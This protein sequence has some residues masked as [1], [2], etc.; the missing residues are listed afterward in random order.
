MKGISPVIASIILI[1]IVLSLSSSYLLFTNRLTS[2]QTE[3]G[4][5]G[6]QELTKR[7]SS[8]FKI[9]GV[10]DQGVIIRNIGAQNI[11]NGSLVVIADDIILNYTMPDDIV[12]DSVGRV[13]I[14]GLW[15]IGPGEHTI[16]VRGT[17]FSDSIPVT[18][19]PVKEGRVLDLRFDEGAG[20]VASD[21]SGNKN[22][23]TLKPNATAGPV[24]AQGKFG[25][26]LRFDGIDDGVSVPDAPTLSFG[27]GAFSVEFWMRSD[28]AN[29]L[30]N[31]VGKGAAGNAATPGY[32]V[33][34]PSN[35]FVSFYSANSTS[36][37]IAP[38]GTGAVTI[39]QWDHI[40]ATT[41]RQTSQ[42]YI[43][44]VL[45]GSVAAVTGSVSN[46]NN[47]RIAMDTGAWGGNYFNG[48]I[49]E[50]RMYN[51]MYTPDQLYV[52]RKQ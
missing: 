12:K 30:N 6:S 25:K 50:V 14:L 45:R 42:I 22:A 15:R 37:T 1:L 52:L 47:V 8:N 27:N 4:Q 43:N 21:S 17:S 19:E 41:N 20:T 48:Y 13:T 28:I 29:N 31:A 11:I 38:S 2:S 46:N 51:S 35:G 49:D 40:L 26:A 44:G 3:A 9:D 18:V 24:W 10:Q 32:T 39:G 33:T 34:G 36:I 16:T 23:G 7:L 5:Q